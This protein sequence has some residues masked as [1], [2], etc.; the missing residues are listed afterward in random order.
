[1]SLAEQL[2]L[3]RDDRLRCRINSNDK[4]E[5]S[6]IFSP[7]RIYLN[8]TVKCHRLLTYCNLFD[9]VGQKKTQRRGKINIYMIDLDA[10]V[11]NDWGEDYRS[12]EGYSS[13]GHKMGLLMS[14]QFESRKLGYRFL[15]TWLCEYIHLRLYNEVFMGG[16]NDVSE[17][18]IWLGLSTQL[19]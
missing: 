10:P 7:D 6:W 1:M 8:H 12:N 14:C 5:S 15:L 2:C 3:S 17:N 18:K 16:G 13:L 4:F 11:K 19:W 9:C